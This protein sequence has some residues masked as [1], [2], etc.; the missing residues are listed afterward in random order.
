M[1]P[2]FGNGHEVGQ[3][4]PVQVSSDIRERAERERSACMA[5]CCADQSDDL[6]FEDLRVENVQQILQRAAQTAMIFGSTQ[7]HCIRISDLAFDRF[8]VL[9]ADFGG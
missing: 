7:Y 3:D 8:D 4:P 1:P 9:S 5:T 2:R 6:R